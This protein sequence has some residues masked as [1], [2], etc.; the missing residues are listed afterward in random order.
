[1]ATAKDLNDKI[2]T[3][4]GLVSS[5]AADLQTSLKD[6]QDEILALKAG[7]VTQ[8]QL[9]DAAAK[10]TTVIDNVANLDATIKGADPG[11]QST[12]PAA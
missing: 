12:D 3:L 6:L 10:L 1:M 9:D 4:T 7:T 2:D 11:P 5:T 8:Q